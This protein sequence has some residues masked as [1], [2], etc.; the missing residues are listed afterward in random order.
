MLRNFARRCC[1]D[2]APVLVEPAPL[3]RVEVAAEGRVVTGLHGADMI[4][5]AIEMVDGVAAL[6]LFI[7]YAGR[8]VALLHR[9]PDI[10]RVFPP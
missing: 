2:G 5:H 6:R 8:H 7:G 3:S 1:P 4:Y 9:E 10:C